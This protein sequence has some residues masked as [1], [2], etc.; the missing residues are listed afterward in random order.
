MLPT[1]RTVG[2]I[3]RADRF[4]FFNGLRLTLTWSSCAAGDE[5]PADGVVIDSA[6][7]GLDES[8]LTRSRIAPWT[9]HSDDR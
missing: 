6:G 5:V 3:V 1:S 7:L 2:E 4:T 8:L 9:P